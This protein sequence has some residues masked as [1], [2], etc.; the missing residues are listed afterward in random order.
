M[1]AETGVHRG[2]SVPVIGNADSTKKARHGQLVEWDLYENMLCRLKV[3]FWQ[4]LVLL[5]GVLYKTL[6]LLTQYCASNIYE[7]V[8][9]NAIK[10]YRKVIAIT[11]KQQLIQ[12]TTN[13]KVINLYHMSQVTLGDW[14]QSRHSHARHLRRW[15]SVGLGEIKQWLYRDSLRSVFSCPCHWWLQNSAVGAAEKQGCRARA[16]A[17]GTQ[18]ALKPVSVIINH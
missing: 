3:Q 8:L 12:N 15:G 2:P 14:C 9:E 6:N 16:W 1:V 11:I 18:A 10:V 4:S 5:Y 17:G 7:M 13:G